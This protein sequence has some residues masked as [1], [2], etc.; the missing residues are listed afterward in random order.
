MDVKWMN[1]WV[2]RDRYTGGCMKGMYGD[3]RVSVWWFRRRVTVLGKGI[4]SIR[5]P[6]KTVVVVVGAL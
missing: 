6:G 2:V 1:S 3:G 5:K 4:L